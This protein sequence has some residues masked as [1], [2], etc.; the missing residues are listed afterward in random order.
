MA[1]VLC[2]GEVLIDQIAEQVAVPRSQVQSWRQC[3]GGA[4]ANVACGLAK[5]GTPVH[6]ISC[7]GQDGR[8]KHCLDFLARQGVQT[9]AVQVHPHAVTREVFVTRDVK[10]DRVFAGFTEQPGAVFAD[11][12]MDARY[13][14]EELFSA[15]DFLV[16]GTLGLAS[17][18]TSRAMGRA[19]KLAE[20]YFV[21]VVVDLNWRPMFWPQ[22][23]LAAPLMRLLLHHAD[24]LKVSAVE[25]LEVLGCSSPAALRQMFDHLEGIVVTDD[26]RACRYLLGD[27]QSKISSFTVEAVDTTGAGDAF[28]AA[29]VH[30]LRQRPLA[31]LA[32]V[33]YAHAV[34]RYACAAGALTTMGIGAITPQPNHH[35]IETFLATRG[36]NHNS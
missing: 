18:Q 34:M 17:E 25:A 35:A 16:L 7:V 20:K 10:G 23:A 11:T 31:D 12:V 2:L 22:P 6:L 19:L 3:V 13:L 14:P 8:G 33:A 4:L 9:A 1:H 24:F 32:D 29:F 30:R 15:A 28:L 27:R 21:P 36:G 26:D 5:L